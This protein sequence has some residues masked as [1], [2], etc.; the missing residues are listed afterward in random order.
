M[1]HATGTAIVLA[2]LDVVMPLHSGREVYE[3]IQSVR[4]GLPVVFSTGYSFG[5]LSGLPAGSRDSTLTKP[6]SRGTLLAAVRAALRHPP[7]DL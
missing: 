4:P 1:V 6:Y 3:E 5:E 2:L 7:S